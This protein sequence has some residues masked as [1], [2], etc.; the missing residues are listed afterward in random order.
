MFLQND[1]LCFT[2][3]SPQ[4]KAYQDN[5]HIVDYLG[6]AIVSFTPSDEDEEPKPPAPD[7]VLTGFGSDGT[8]R[9]NTDVYTSFTLSSN[10]DR[11]KEN[12]ISYRMVGSKQGT[13]CT[14]TTE[15][16]KG[17]S[18]LIWCKWRTLLV[19]VG[20]TA[21]TISAYA[22]GSKVG[23]FE[24]TYQNIEGFDPPDTKANDKRPAGWHPLSFTTPTTLTN[25]WSKWYS[26]KQTDMAHAWDYRY[27]DCDHYNWSIMG[28][29]PT[30]DEYD[31]DG[32]YVATH[33]G[34]PIY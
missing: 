32:K 14:D 11:T 10:V 23:Q 16:P 8:Y 20:Y 31:K 12:P 24:I 29:E 7:P 25:T 18:Q 30:W 1:D 21:E 19:S 2:A 17:K 27:Y 3:R 33:G 4:A 22:D 34:D 5:D 28:Y 13:L 9:Y 26:V 15:I 6:M